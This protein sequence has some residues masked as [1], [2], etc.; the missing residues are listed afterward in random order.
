MPESKTFC[1]C[2]GASG[3]F[4]SDG[5]GAQTLLPKGSNS[6]KAVSAEEA[7][8]VGKQSAR[9]KRTKIKRSAFNEAVHETAQTARELS[10]LVAVMAPIWLP[11]L[12]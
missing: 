8:I 10:L 12:K 7:H 1:E 6:G 4:R 11:F 5:D 9:K 3:T 2:P